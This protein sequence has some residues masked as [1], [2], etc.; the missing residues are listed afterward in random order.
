MPRVGL[1]LSR[2]QEAELKDRYQSARGRKDLDM[3]LRIQGL[4]LVHRGNTESVAADMIGV[5]RRT[6]QV[7]IRRYRQ[8]G[9][10]GLVK[11]PYLGGRSRLTEEQ[12]AELSEIIATGP[13]EAGFDTGVWI[14]P[15]VV[16][17]V[18]DLYGVSYSAS[19]IGRILHKL[20]FSLQYPTRKPSKA[21]EKAEEQWRA[22]DLPAIKK[23]QAGKGRS[24]IP[25]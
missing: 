15:M 18:K 13:E 4:L 22:E 21:D 24:A 10:S 23:S 3:C 8:R 1:R 5:G 20:R 17:L 12:K 16:K 7:W 6:L 11:G 25:G 2:N 9:I 19:Q 14:A